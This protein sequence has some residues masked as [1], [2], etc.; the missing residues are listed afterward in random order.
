[1]MMNILWYTPQ[2]LTSVTDQSGVTEILWLCSNH[3]LSK[4]PKIQLMWFY[5]STEWQSFV[6]LLSVIPAVIR[7][8]M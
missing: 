5:C 6:L 3:K 2:A 8:E 4:R 7:S 1:M